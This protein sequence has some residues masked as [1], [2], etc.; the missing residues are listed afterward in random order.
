MLPKLKTD[1]ALCCQ[2]L[3]MTLRLLPKH[4][5]TVSELG[6]FLPKLETDSA[7][8]AKAKTDSGLCYQSLKQTRRF[9]TKAYNGLCTLCH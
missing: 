4:K 9:V 6:L 3:K 2:S 5:K 8:V 1:S 7:F